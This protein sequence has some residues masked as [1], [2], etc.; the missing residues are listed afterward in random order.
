MGSKII[1]LVM[2]AFQSISPTHVHEFNES[3]SVIL[4]KRPVKI[5]PAANRLLQAQ[6]IRMHN[7]AQPA[8]PLQILGF[9]LY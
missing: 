8:K 3:F 9:Q 7:F 6:W 1:G 2:F 4:A 5:D